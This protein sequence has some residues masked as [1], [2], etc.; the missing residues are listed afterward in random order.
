MSNPNAAS[1][2]EQ[3]KSAASSLLKK[4]IR[5]FLNNKLAVFG[6][7]VVVVMTLACII[8]AIMGVDYAT[9]DLTNM[10]AAP[11]AG[12]IFGTD[13]I[14]RDL[15]A[16]VLIGGCYSI[17]IGVFCAVLSS[18]IGAA[19]GAIAGYF[20][21][22]VDSVIVRISEI[23]QAFP[24][25][26]LVMM[27][28]AI[29]NQRGLGNLLFI[30]VVT[31]WMT[32]FRMVRNEFM[33]LKNET[34][35]KVCEAFGMKRSNIMFKQILPNVMSPIIVST[36]TNVAFFILQEASLSFIGLGVAD[37]TPTWGNILNAA[38]SVSVVTNQWWI[39]VFPGLAISLF[40]LAINF[41]G[42]GLRDVLDPKQQ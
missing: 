1:I 38:K 23:F 9:P 8:G 36:T 29:L 42:D 32:T 35:V 16:R 15:L 11:E 21:G 31:G 18:V 5:K 41:F 24:Q 40:V 12:H 14:G 25:L 13:T 34:Y 20:G 26:V 27:L 30:F 4:N 33:S 39:W 17:L 22:W 19:L 10:K 3:N 6:L 37:S 7:V 2:K 28:V